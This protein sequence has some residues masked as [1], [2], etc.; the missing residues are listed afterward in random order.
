M[1]TI[2]TIT[3]M[4]NDFM[5]ALLDS[6]SL[7]RIAQEPITQSPNTKSKKVPPPVHPVLPQSSHI[8]IQAQSQLITWSVV[9]FVFLA[10]YLTNTPQAL[11]IDFRLAMFTL[12]D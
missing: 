7:M 9:I 2:S 5:Y 3:L 4:G 12:L 1:K 6:G 11:A 10:P 8:L